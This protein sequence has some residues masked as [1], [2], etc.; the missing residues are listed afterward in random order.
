MKKMRVLVA[1]LGAAL[2]IGAFPAT[3]Q[4]THHCSELPPIDEQGT[5]H[6]IWVVCED[7]PH[8]PVGV[9]KYI[10]CWLSPTC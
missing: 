4:A 8:Q 6:T 7:G 9:V 10:I 1:T 5:T 3:A 2:A